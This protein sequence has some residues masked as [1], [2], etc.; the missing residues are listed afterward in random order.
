[1]LKPDHNNR[2]HHSVGE[3]CSSPE[4]FIHRVA[5]NCRELVIRGQQKQLLKLA[6]EKM[7]LVEKE[8]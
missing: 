7:K 3:D 2:R 8:T 6:V 5:R 1:M 4:G